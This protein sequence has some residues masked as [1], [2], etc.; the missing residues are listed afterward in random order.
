MEMVD[1]NKPLMKMDQSLPLCPPR[2][3]ASLMSKVSRWMIL[4]SPATMD[5]ENTRVNFKWFSVKLLMYSLC[6]F[7][8]FAIVN[9]VSYLTGLNA[10]LS[11]LNPAKSKNII[12][13]GSELASMAVAVSASVFP[14]L[15]ASGIPSISGLA[16]TRDLASPKYGKVFI[17]GSLLA[18]VGMSFGKLWGFR[19]YTNSLP[20]SN[21]IQKYDLIY[22]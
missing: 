2:E 20:L 17:F 6:N 19:Q 8:P 7:G 11:D 22:F 3:T 16:L 9:L 12:D 1:G 21:L 15:F 13:T 14:F 4:L 5:R 18:Y 10:Q